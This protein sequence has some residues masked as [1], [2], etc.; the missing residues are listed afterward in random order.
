MSLASLRPVLAP[1]FGAAICLAVM[2]RPGATVKDVTVAQF[3]AR[4]LAVADAKDAGPI[5]IVI[6]RWSSDQELESLRKSLITNDSN[7]L[8][9]VFQK[10]LPEAGGVLVPG[11]PAVGA[12]VRSRRTRS[13]P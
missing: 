10:A 3:V 7:P 4:A 2:P 9:P 11:G 12:R 13:V 5:E 6:K 8:L 1:L